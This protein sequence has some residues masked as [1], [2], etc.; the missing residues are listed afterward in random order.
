MKPDCGTRVRGHAVLRVVN[1]QVLMATEG[2]ILSELLSSI[3]LTNAVLRAND[4]PEGGLTRI[5][6][7]QKPRQGRRLCCSDALR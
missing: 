1:N 4:G 3:R 5:C 2:V 7:C 6:F